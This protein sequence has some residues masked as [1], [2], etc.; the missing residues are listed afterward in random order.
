VVRVPQGRTGTGRGSVERSSEREEQ[1]T[2]LREQQRKAR[3][4]ERAVREA[5]DR[6]KKA[7]VK[8]R[9]S[10]RR[11]SEFEPVSSTVQKKD[12]NAGPVVRQQSYNR[13]T[14]GG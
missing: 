2:R 6:D 8:T 11:A 4:R 9:A 10:E 14:P 7:V 1:A 5:A 3:E 12:S 13:V